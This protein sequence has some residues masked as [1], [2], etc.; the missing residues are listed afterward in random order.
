MNTLHHR[1]PWAF[2]APV[3]GALS[4]ALGPASALYFL[5]LSLH[6]HVWIVRFHAIHSLLLSSVFVAG[7]LTLT[8]AEALFP[9]FTATLVREFRIVAMI[10]AVPV[11]MMAMISA[12]KGYRFAPIPIIHEL[13]V[14]LA[15][16]PDHGEG[17]GNSAPFRKN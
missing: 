5:L 9:W 13:A 14:K 10:G 4:Y 6:K 8:T 12:L 15:R 11:W 3:C 1:A 17:R 2:S 7:W 16:H